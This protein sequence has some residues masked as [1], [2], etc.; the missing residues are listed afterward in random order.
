MWYRGSITVPKM[1]DYVQMFG[2]HHLVVVPAIMGL[3]LKDPRIRNRDGISVA[4]G[5]LAAELRP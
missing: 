3:M 4:S 1:F 5:K 2:M